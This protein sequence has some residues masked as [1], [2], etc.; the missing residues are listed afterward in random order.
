VPWIIAILGIIFSFG[1]LTPLA[2]AEAA[3][4]EVGVVVATAL[5]TATVT[6]VGDQL[7]PFPEGSSLSQKD[8]QDFAYHFGQDTRAAISD[9]ANTTFLGLKDDGGFT[10]L[11]VRCRMNKPQL[12]STH[13]LTLPLDSDYIRGGAFVDS[14]VLPPTKD[15]ESFYGKQMVSRTINVKWR[16]DTFTQ[17]GDSRIQRPH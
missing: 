4:A 13:S 11:Y 7:E 5:M 6:T 14:R 15:I 17:L 16:Y 12:G 3:I 10:I 2:V 1:L 8:M 9:W